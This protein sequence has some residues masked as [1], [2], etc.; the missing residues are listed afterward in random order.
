MTSYTG[1]EPVSGRAGTGGSIFR[2]NFLSLPFLFLRQYWK[3][4]YLP[5]YLKEIEN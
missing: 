5:H 3:E 2:E 1:G 4:Q